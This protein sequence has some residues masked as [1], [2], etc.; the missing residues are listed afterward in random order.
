LD[1]GARV[2]D[3]TAFVVLG[4]VCC[5]VDCIIITAACNRGGWVDEITVT[6]AKVVDVV[7]K[8]EIVASMDVVSTIVAVGV[9][10]SVPL[11]EST[12]MGIQTA[13]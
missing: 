12:I 2:V 10:V 3:R 4:A 13:I 7:V 8:V 11:C 1:V 9:S 5:G 6:V